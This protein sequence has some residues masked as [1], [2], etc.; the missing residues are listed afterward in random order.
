MR[1]AKPKPITP[2][3]EPISKLRF[4]L[5]FESASRGYSTPVQRVLKRVVGAGFAARSNLE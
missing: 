3:L 5:G 1:S 2:K 4:K